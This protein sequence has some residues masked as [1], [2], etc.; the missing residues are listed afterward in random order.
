MALARKTVRKSSETERMLAA[1]WERNRCARPA[2][3][4]DAFAAS[5]MRTE[6]TDSGAATVSP[7][8]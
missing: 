2:E 6:R 8:P 5:R 4:T 3:G 1:E 7:L